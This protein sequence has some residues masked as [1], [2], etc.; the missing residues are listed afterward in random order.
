M[1]GAAP[2]GGSGWSWQCG[3]RPAA[4][5]SANE[6]PL[7][8]KK[9]Q[10][11]KKETEH[12][13]L[14][15]CPPPLPPPARVFPRER[16]GEREGGRETPTQS[17]REISA[18]TDT[19]HAGRMRGILRPPEQ[20]TRGAIRRS[21]RAPSLRTMST[22][23]TGQGRERVLPVTARPQDTE[24]WDTPTARPR[25]HTARTQTAT[26]QR[27]ALLLPLRSSPALSLL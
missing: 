10:K 26:T 6:Q 17:D 7:N 14:L 23:V 20:D 4:G 1:F 24:T 22:R 21:R 5:V 3:G 27:E 16:E 13:P 12:A 2:A 9:E 8:R 18:P 25:E 19:A 11:K 15:R